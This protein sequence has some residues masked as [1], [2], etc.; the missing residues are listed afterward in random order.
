MNGEVIGLMIE[1]AIVILLNDHT[2]K[3]TSKCLHI[4]S[5]APGCLA[6]EATFRSEQKSV[7]RYLTGLSA[8]IRD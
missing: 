2:V 4:L 5:L 1:P 8:E 3:L 6:Q 7:G